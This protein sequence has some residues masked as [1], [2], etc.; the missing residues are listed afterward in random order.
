[1]RDWYLCKFKANVLSSTGF[2]AGTLGKRSEQRNLREIFISLS[3]VHQMI[4][5]FIE[6]YSTYVNN[7]PFLRQVGNDISLRTTEELHKSS[8]YYIR[9]LKEGTESRKMREL[10]NRAIRDLREYAR[11]F[12]RVASVLDKIL[13]YNDGA[14][15]EN[16]EMYSKLVACQERAA[17][18]ILNNGQ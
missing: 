1:M 15:S 10:V 3:N 8:L 13:L 16:D 7:N 17:A 5:R 14:L 4:I 9:W 12:R 18:E 11:L 2:D 6:F